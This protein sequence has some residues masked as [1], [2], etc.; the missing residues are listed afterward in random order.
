MTGNEKVIQAIFNAVEEVNRLLPEN[1]Q[2]VK[3]AD[4]VLYGKFGK[5]DSLG[6]VNL[7][8]TTEQKIE[9]E[10][11]VTI[12]LADESTMSQDQNPFRTIGTLADYA[13]LLLKEK[14]SG[15]TKA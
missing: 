13:F 6:L 7:I 14:T 1:Q 15:Q 10:F 4:T 2:L 12:T 9:E 5:L 3:S 11:G 8:V